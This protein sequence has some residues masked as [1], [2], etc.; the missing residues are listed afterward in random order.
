MRSKISS[1]H[2][3]ETKPRRRTLSQNDDKTL[4]HEFGKFMGKFGVPA[5]GQLGAQ[6]AAKFLP[7]NTYQLAMDVA[8]DPT[9]VLKIVTDILTMRGELLNTQNTSELWEVKAIIGSGYLNMNPALITV[10]IHQ[11]PF[12]QTHITILGSAKEGLIKQRAGEKAVHLIA[13]CLTEAL[14]Q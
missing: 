8:T 4:N 7:K 2:V 11:M 3:T 14:Q 10:Q 5:S 6:L 13:Q 1:I 12:N 9:S